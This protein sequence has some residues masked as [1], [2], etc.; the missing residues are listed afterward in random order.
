MAARLTIGN[1]AHAQLLPRPLDRKATK[2]ND[3]VET[4]S[5]PRLLSPTNEVRR[6]PWSCAWSAKIVTFSL[7]IEDSNVLN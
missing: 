2:T 1:G 7:C 3:K 6:L 4:C 5:R